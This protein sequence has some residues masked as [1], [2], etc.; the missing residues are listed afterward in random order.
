LAAKKLCGGQLHSAI[1][2]HF[3]DFPAGDDF[4]SVI[5]PPGIFWGGL[6][7]RRLRVVLEG[8]KERTHM[9]FRR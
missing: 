1:T 5:F 6:P 9:V 3:G 7:S 4:V 8:V 2:S